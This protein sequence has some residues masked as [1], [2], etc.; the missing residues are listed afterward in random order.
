LKELGWLEYLQLNKGEYCLLGICI[1]MHLLGNGSEEG[2]GQ[3]LGFFNATAKLMSNELAPVPH[4]GWANL[5][6]L[7]TN[8]IL[9]QNEMNKFYFSHSY[10]MDCKSEKDVTSVFSYGGQS[11]PAIISKENIMGVQFHPEKSHRYGFNLF[12]NFAELNV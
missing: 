2:S 7:E 4:V 3:G 10:F 9:K 1:G 6:I 5:Q 12:R 8:P 11:F